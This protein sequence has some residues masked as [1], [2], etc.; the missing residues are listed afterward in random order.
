MQKKVVDLSDILSCTIRY[1][2]KELFYTLK[3]QNLLKKQKNLNQ[4]YI[5][6]NNGIQ[7]NSYV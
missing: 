7:N 3:K 5:K 1:S 2:W 6:N 4:I